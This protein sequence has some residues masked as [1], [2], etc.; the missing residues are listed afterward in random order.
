MVGMIGFEPMAFYTQNRCDD[1]AS[2][3]PENI[4][5]IARYFLMD[6]VRF[7]LTPIFK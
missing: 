3:H 7:E 2:Q 5:N 1:L 6:K 4:F